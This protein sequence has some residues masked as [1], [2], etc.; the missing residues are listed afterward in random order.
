VARIFIYV[1]TD[2]FT[3]LLTVITDIIVSVA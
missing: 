1:K 3:S 2:I